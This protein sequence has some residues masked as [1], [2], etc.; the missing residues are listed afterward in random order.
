MSQ[1]DFDFVA[2]DETYCNSYDVYRRGLLKQQKA[3]VSRQLIPLLSERFEPTKYRILGVGSGEG[4]LDLLLLAE[5][6]AEMKRKTFDCEI[7]Y[8][9]IERNASFISRFQNRVKMHEEVLGGVKF[10]WYH[11]VF[12]EFISTSP[13][14]KYDLIHFA[15]SLYYMDAEK[16]LAQCMDKLLLPGGRLMSVV[17]T[18]E[19]IYA[20]N[21]KKFKG[22]V[23]N[24]FD[25]FNVIC[26]RD[27]EA[28]A[29]KHGWKCRIE[30][31][32]RI[33]DLTDMLGGKIE[34][35]QGSKL[36]DFFFHADHLLESLDGK[37]LKEIL[38]HFIENCKLENGKYLS[39]GHEAIVLFVN[40]V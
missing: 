9:V 16:A 27:L 19:S 13:P 10:E 35:E 25:N 7:L 26:G 5:I 30:T 36:F 33:L 12:E 32:S 15:H 18:E 20:K 17:Q 24:C 3:W 22:Q 29:E 8:T 21:C 2:Q 1:E 14:D 38:Q 4:D 28:I 39:V 40:D 6:R 23:A 11:G 34:S 37:K 31:G